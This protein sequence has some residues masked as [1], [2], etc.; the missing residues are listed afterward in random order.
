MQTKQLN[1]FADSEDSVPVI[2][3]GDFNARPVSEPMKVLLESNWL[4]AVAPQS[5]IDY[6]LLLRCDP[7]KIVDVQIMDE[8]TASDHDPVLVTLQWVGK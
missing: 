8:P 2:L 7:W 5:R 4:D 6:V 1:E 3:A